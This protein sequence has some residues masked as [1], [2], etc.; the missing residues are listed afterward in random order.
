MAS[1]TPQEAQSAAQAQ[2]QLQ[3]P[4]RLSTPGGGCMDGASSHA[5]APTTQ[6]SCRSATSASGSEDVFSAL[7]GLRDGQEPSSA[8]A[9]AA[10][11]SSVW[12]P[13]CLETLPSEV[14]AHIAGFLDVDDLLRASRTCHRL[15]TISLDPL[16]HYYRLRDARFLLPP[17]L[18]SPYRPS[19]TELMSRS[20]FLTNNTVISRRLARSLVSI[21]LSRR[22]ASRPSAKDLVQRSVLPQECVPG[23][24]PVHVA[25]GLVAKRKAIE[26]ERLKDGLR[27]WISGKWKGEVKER[28]E[29]VR[30][31]DEIRGTGR[32]W[33]LRRFWERVSH[34]ELSAH[35]NESSIGRMEPQTEW[36]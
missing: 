14:L 35:Q 10:A 1:S 29:D 15:R 30:R 27:Q 19:L 23:M 32:V 36:Q 6:D 18:N 2:T 24:F 7:S 25:P 31:C 20:I 21:R 13:P 28:E 26:K 17:L 33:R 22:L 12:S 9:T 5:V 4:L 34:G 8:A 16:L 11:L 3:L